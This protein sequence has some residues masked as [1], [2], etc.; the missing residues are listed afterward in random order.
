MTE[1]L[2]I[3]E[4]TAHIFGIAGLVL[5]VIAY[6]CKRHK[7]TMIFKGAQELAF[8]VQYALLGAYT[9]VVMNILGCIRNIIF[10]KRLEKNRSVRVFQ[11]VFGVIFLVMGVF[12]WHGAISIFAILGKTGETAA[13]GIKDARLMRYAVVPTLLCWI[14]YNFYCHA[15]AAVIN[16][17]FSLGSIFVSLVLARKLEAAKSADGK[18]TN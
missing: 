5:A 16:D 11:L 10:G 4:I 13:F 3:V 14:V 9:G 8:A 1:G 18:N 15:Y 2:S 6:Q 7:M 17:L 12:S